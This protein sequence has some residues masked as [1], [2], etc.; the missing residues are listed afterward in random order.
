MHDRTTKNPDH[1]CLFAE[2]STQH[3][4]FTA[5]Q[6]RSCGFASDVLAYHARTGRFLRLRRGLYRLRD[7]P[8]SPHEEVVRAWLAVGADAAVV[9]H[10]S[11]LDLLGL[12]DIVPNAVHLTVP[13][14]RRHLRALPGVRIHTAIKPLLPE[15][16]TMRD[17]L[18]LTSATRTILDAAEAGTA[19]E[20]IELAVAQALERGLTTTLRLAEGARQRS[21]RVARLI[22]AS[23]ADARS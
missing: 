22:E 5:E 9:S 10:E 23:L 19:P 15:D 17:G 1:A 13:R 3:G 14:S 6:A 20:Q 12:S 8:S 16:T 18:R 2:A 21:R 11:A 4:Y 7:Y